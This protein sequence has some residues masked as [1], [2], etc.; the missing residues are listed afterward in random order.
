MWLQG[1]YI[2]E[3]FAIVLNN[4][5]GKKGSKKHKYPDK[6][7]EIYQDKKSKPQNVQV[8]R[9]DAV[10]QLNNLMSKWSKNNGK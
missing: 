5:F 8:A 3:G 10:N 6:P 9:E 1:L 7:Y 2:H 4:A